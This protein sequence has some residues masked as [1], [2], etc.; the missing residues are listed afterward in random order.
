MKQ[1]VRNLAVVLLLAGMFNIFCI[2]VYAEMVEDVELPVSEPLFTEGN[3]QYYLDDN[4]L[5]K[6]ELIECEPYTN[7]RKQYIRPNISEYKKDKEL[8]VKCSYMNITQKDIAVLSNPSTRSLWLTRTDEAMNSMGNIKAKLSV[9]YRDTDGGFSDGTSE[10]SLKWAT[11]SWTRIGAVEGVYP[12]T[13]ELYYNVQGTIYD[14]NGEFVKNGS[15]GKTKKFSSPTFSNVALMNGYTAKNI[16]A[17]GVS[18]TIHCTRSVNIT[19]YMQ[20]Y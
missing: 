5:I 17:A 9:V 19:V 14:A 13:S 4:E 15:M 2:S 1:I 8:L 11:G 7:L 18:Y 10:L 16:V 12:E 6:V 3:T 20:F